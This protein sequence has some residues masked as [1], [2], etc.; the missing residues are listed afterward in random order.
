VTA[1]GPATLNDNGDPASL[2]GTTPTLSPGAS[3]EP[4]DAGLIVPAIRALL[5]EFVT[6]RAGV[7]DLAEAASCTT[8]V[9]F[10]PPVPVLIGRFDAV[11]V[12]EGVDLSWEVVSDEE[13]LGFRIYRG[14]EGS[15]REEISPAGLISPQ[16][17][18]YRDDVAAGGRTYEYT[19]GVVVADH[20]EVVSRSVSV[21]TRAFALALRQNT[22]NPFNPTT[23]ISF[24]LPE[25]TRVTVSIYDVKGRR[26]RTLVDESID[27]GY[28]ERIW[29]GKD[30]GGGQ[31][32]TGIYFYSL[33]A[34]DRRLTRKMLLLK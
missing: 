12:E 20:S 28:H 4:P 3:Y 17:R 18:S 30:D 1:E 23:V 24:T 33:T 22:P 32:S 2:S 7:N 26:V 14:L 16:A 6:Y 10:E 29:D 31:V 13:I 8:V 19:L 25:K 15:T 34:D 27:E 21:T 11:A 9:K 5:Y